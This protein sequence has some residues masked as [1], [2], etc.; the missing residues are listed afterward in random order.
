MFQKLLI[1]AFISL[2][3]VIQSANSQYS[4][5]LQPV[6]LIYN[7]NTLPAGIAPVYSSNGTILAFGG[8]VDQ[9]PDGAILPYDTGDYYLLRAKSPDALTSLEISIPHVIF[10]QTLI[11]KTT[12]EKAEM[13]SRYGWG[14]TRLS[15]VEKAAQTIP[16]FLLPKITDADTTIA[17]LISVIT[18]QSS[19]QVIA[20]LSS[21]DTRYSYAPGCRQAEQYIFDRFDS[22]HLATSFFTYQYNNVTMRDVIGQLIGATHPE[23]IIV[24]CG[25]LDCTSETPSQRAPGAEDNGTGTAA[26]IE[27]ARALS[28]HRTDL[29]V[30]FVAFS[31]EEQGLIGSSFYASNLQGLG[32]KIA[33]V[34]NVDMVGYSGLYA[35]DI[36]I[37]SDPA[38]YS[39]G[40]L[41]AEILS[42]YT[43]LDTIPHYNSGPEYGSDHYSFA[44]RGYPSIFFIDAWDGFDWYPYYHTV[45]DTLANLNLEQQASVTRAVAAM[46]ATLARLQTG[47]GPTYLSGDANGSG[48]VT[49]LDV[50]FLVRYF[51]GMGPAPDP[52]LM[53]DANGSCTTT[54]LDIT[55]L[56]R[57]FKGIGPA[58]Q[59]GNCR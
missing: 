53:G 46:A 44:I 40:E 2:P 58:P 39:L 17:N 37:F 36:H 20:A 4:P 18:P 43:T 6:L 34:I 31:G 9:S 22:L 7:S 5:N 55:Y 12:P 8:S 3:M 49:G 47:T 57:Y 23:S 1:I 54:G 11:V 15:P 45:A 33:A 35:Q 10:G 27:A 29:T 14:L 41:G 51:K 42:T 19:G 50:V 38:S 48:D 32:E 28:G 21:I 56:V 16:E 52:L 13:L 30:R 25:H 26:V 24:V 59:Y